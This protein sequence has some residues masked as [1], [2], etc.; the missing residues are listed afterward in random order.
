MFAHEL[1]VTDVKIAIGRLARGLLSC[2]VGDEDEM[3]E[4]G[5]KELT[6]KRAQPWGG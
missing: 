6:A 5:K 1:R 3:T 4:A 2:H